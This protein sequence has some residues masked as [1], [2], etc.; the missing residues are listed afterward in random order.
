AAGREVRAESIDVELVKDWIRCCENWH[1]QACDLGDHTPLDH[2]QDLMVIDVVD[3][4]LVDVPCSSRYM[5]LSYVWGGISSLQT[6]KTNLKQHQQPGGLVA[7]S[8]ALPKTISDAIKLTSSIGERYLWVDAL[9]I[10]QDDLDGKLSL[11]NQMDKIYQNAVCTIV[12]AFGTDS[13]AGLPGV[14]SPRNSAQQTLDYGKSR[15]IAISQRPF[16]MFLGREGHSGCVWNKR[17]W[18]HQE[19]LLSGRKLVFLED[20]V[21]FNC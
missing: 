9:C 15:R 13:S 20:G 11:I 2:C 21:H 16:E 14:T 18:T 10:V 12:A 7:Q 8:A 6:L 17:A 4:R 1:G 3:G 5:A 19:R